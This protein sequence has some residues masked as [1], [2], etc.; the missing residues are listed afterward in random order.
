MRIIFVTNNASREPG[1]VAHHLSDLGIAT[2]PREVLTAA[3]AVARLA[4]KELSPGAKVL[5][6]G[7]AG[8]RTAIDEAGF[9]R[10]D[11][12][13]DVPD[14]VVQG[15]APE[16]S[17][18]ELA[19][20]AYAIQ[21]GARYFASNLDLTLPNE[22]GIAPGNG[23]LVG[24]VVNATGVLPLSAGKPEPAMFLLASEL[25]GAQRPLAIGD[26]LDTDLRGARSASVP[27]LLVLT[28]VSTAA[29]AVLAD[30]HERPS[31]LGEDL[32]ALAQSHPAPRR[33]GE[34]WH[35]GQN[36]AHVEG[37]QLVVDGPAGIDRL[38]A[39]CAAAWDSTDHGKPVDGGSLPDLGVSSSHE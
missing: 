16:V 4:A 10:V 36:S 28:G 33:E 3:Q 29:D 11:T 5:V 21:G 15:F 26:R 39:A 35:V 2:Q 20:A 31:F 34:R 6:V 22:R 1:E 30:P 19:E 17:W 38:R 24:T 25:V 7:G 8:L 12:A 23:S 32:G 14:A 18:R 13:N 9:T 27:G 37:K